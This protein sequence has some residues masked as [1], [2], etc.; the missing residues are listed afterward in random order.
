MVKNVMRRFKLLYPLAFLMIPPKLA[1][2]IASLYRTNR[3]L[4]RKRIENRHDIK[5]L[6]YMSALIRDNNPVPPLELLV[7]NASHLVFDHF[8]SASVLAAGFHFLL[9]NPEALDKLQRELREAFKSYD[10]ITDSALQE[11]PWLRA[12]IEEILRI[13]TNVPY[14]LPRI[15]PGTTVDGHY[16]AKG[17]SE[18]EAFAN[19][20]D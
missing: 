15:S 19:V 10:D 1:I 13:H 2:C 9:S 20:V 17:V 8:E 5:Q 16:I 7:S 12:V 3:E 18:Y 6:D 11:L 14:G 4:M